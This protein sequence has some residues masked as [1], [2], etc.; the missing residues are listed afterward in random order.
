M[1]KEEILNKLD[2]VVDFTP[3]VNQI[4]IGSL[5]YNEILQSMQEYAELYH[6][7]QTED[8]WVKC[9]DRLPNNGQKVIMFIPEWRTPIAYGNYNLTQFNAINSIGTYDDV[10][11]NVKPTHWQPIPKA[12]KE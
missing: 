6:T 3:S 2:F 7:Q 1:E 5:M 11:Y 12:P 4:Q 10:D 8:K 9:S